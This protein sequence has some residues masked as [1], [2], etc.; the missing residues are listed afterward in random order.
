MLNV[1]GARLTGVAET[2]AR[3]VRIVGQYML[4]WFLFLTDG[5]E[6]MGSERPGYI[7]IRVA[8]IPEA[9]L[10]RLSQE[11][12]RSRDN[13][14]KREI[15]SEQVI[16]CFLVWIRILASAVFHVPF[17]DTHVP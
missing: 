5:T 15:F 4:S 3:Q 10:C 11:A 1:P 13:L 2:R 7:P 12:A 9:I 14:R 8:G 16:R 17:L 6:A